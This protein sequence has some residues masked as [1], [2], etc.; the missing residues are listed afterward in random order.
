MGR[1]PR[2]PAADVLPAGRRV[3]QPAEAGG[4]WRG[5]ERLGCAGRRQERLLRH[6]Q[7]RRPRAFADL[8]GRG[9]RGGPRWC[10]A[11]VRLPGGSHYLPGHDGWDD[12]GQ[13]R[14]PR[15][16]RRPVLRRAHG[17]VRQ[18]LPRRGRP[19]Q[20]GQLARRDRRDRH[21]R[22]AARDGPRPVG[23]R[24]VD[25]GQAGGEGPDGRDTGGLQVHHRCGRQDDAPA[26]RPGVRPVGAGA[27]DGG[28][29]RG[30]AAHGL[31]CVFHRRPVQGGAGD[32]ER[33]E[34]PQ[35]GAAQHLRRGDGGRSPGC[36]GG[37]VAPAGVHAGGGRRGRGHGR[38]DG[39]RYDVRFPRGCGRCRR[40]APEPGEPAA[41]APGA[42]GDL[43]G[44]LEEDGSGRAGRRAGA[45]PGGDVRP[46]G[47]G[48][49]GCRAREDG[50]GGH[51][52]RCAAGG[53]RP[54]RAGGARAELRERDAGRHV[55]DL[56]GQLRHRRPHGAGV[57][58]H[59]GRPVR[60]EPG[61][62]AGAVPA[63]Q[64]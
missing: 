57:H 6:R 53:G 17:C 24:A 31:G 60:A 41:P 19:V 46:E 20:R 39:C 5:R 28:A 51:P 22:A 2:D 63:A 52:G 56:E 42:A 44:G 30:P 23:V 47:G 48:E 36:A 40:P 33:V 10:G 9:C 35:G 49:G 34:L 37:H 25:A 14:H 64:W 13:G 55:R 54:A 8:D 50:R 29:E 58:Q 38:C 18:R 4:A 27:G 43:G 11:A 21:R 26:Q 7:E 32:C 3:H 15:A 1:G 61:W 12:R 16:E 59:G 62:A 45:V